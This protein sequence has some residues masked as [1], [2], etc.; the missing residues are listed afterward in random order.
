M[1]HH[2]LFAPLRFAF[3]APF[4]V[5]GHP[6]TLQKYIFREMGKTFLLA[7][8]GLTGVLGLG[9]GLLQ[10]MKFGETTPEQ[11]VRLMGLL[12]P[13]SASLTLPI[14]ALFSAAATYGRLSADNE[15]V[16][17]RSSGINMN[18]LFVPTIVLS[19][20]AAGASFGLTNYVIP[21]MVRGLN[22]LLRADLG[23]L[24]QQQL[25][26]PQ[27]LALDR[28]R[29][30]ADE[31]GADPADAERITLRRVAFVETDEE[32]W[33]RY[34]TAREINLRF[35][36][37]EQ[38]VRVSGWMSN[39][40]YY[41]ARLD[42]FV[43][44][45][46]QVIPTNEYKSGVRLK[47]KFLNLNELL[48]YRASPGKWYEVRDEIER[49]RKSVGATLLS[50]AIGEAFR[51]GGVITLQD[52]RTR[53]LIEPETVRSDPDTA[54]LEFSNVRI[55]ETQGGRV[56]TIAADRASIK[57]GGGR[58]LDECTLAI[59]VQDARLASGGTVIE[60][61]KTTLTPVGMPPE[62]VERAA[63]MS[64]AELLAGPSEPLN[65]PLERKRFMARAVRGE[66]VRKIVAAIHERAAFSV[67]IFMLSILGAALGVILRGSHLMTAFG[68]S[69]VPMLFVLVMIVTGKQMS[70]NPGTHELGLLVIW[71]GIIVVVGVD[72]LIMTRLLRR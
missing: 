45:A 23:K 54:S 41:D 18:V 36:V 72:V 10:M 64:E 57:M 39:L 20:V 55:E 25:N 8:V 38:S 5:S 61:A 40:S 29:I 37:D 17:C 4:L 46:S 3:A 2:L 14:A 27:G 9:G 60:R 69:F 24:I 56:R 49:L 31:Y 7:A 43:E 68:I 63:A 35:A 15:F 19:L 30:C 21:G 33:V 50:E 11:V 70:R 52:E 28:Y 67:S 58:T 66:T 65:E 1:P 22:E 51:R 12:I 32:A 62:I 16:A 53:Y 13:L 42:R 47:I 26:Q 6:W 34:G 48:H 59:E 71:S 44:E